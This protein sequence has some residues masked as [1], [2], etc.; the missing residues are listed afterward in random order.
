MYNVAIVGKFGSGKSTLA[1][2][3]VDH[4]GYT[5]VANAGALKQ[6]AAM[7]YGEIDKSQSYEITQIQTVNLGSNLD[8]RQE[9]VTFNVSGR[10][11]LQG[12]GQVVKEFDRNFWL[13]A[14]MRDAATKAGPFVC[15]DTRFPFEADFLR[16]NGWIIV[17]LYVPQEIRMERYKDIYGRYP[18]ETEM[19]HPSETMTDDITEDL[20]LSGTQSPEEII[21]MLLDHM[22]WRSM[23]A[24][25][26]SK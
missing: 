22:E 1:E 24:N 6:L 10:E 15:D 21:E 3:L 20:A 26:D 11:I 2:R 25:G 13:K 14:M 8:Y 12:L 17:K 23:N 9:E 5:R 4:H 18:T 19:N 7:A 16:D